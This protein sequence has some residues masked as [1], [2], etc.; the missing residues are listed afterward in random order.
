[1]AYRSRLSVVEL[2]RDEWRKRAEAAA[3]PRTRT[4]YVVRRRPLGARLLAAV[5]LVVLGVLVGG[6]A[7]PHADDTPTLREDYDACI[8]TAQGTRRSQGDRHAE[9]LG[10]L[11]A[12][13]VYDAGAQG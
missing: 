8:S 7:I 6:G 11:H 9:L 10:A 2:E 5:W 4:E 12:C 3:R 1:M 13:G